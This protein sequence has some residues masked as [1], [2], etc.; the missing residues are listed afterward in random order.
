M[1]HYRTVQN[2][3]SAPVSLRFGTGFFVPRSAYP[4]RHRAGVNFLREELVMRRVALV[5]CPRPSLA[6]RQDDLQREEQV[7]LHLMLHY[8]LHP[9]HGRGLRG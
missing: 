9:I 3:H 6:E 4:T 2:A 7:Y 5:D 1:Q 8:E